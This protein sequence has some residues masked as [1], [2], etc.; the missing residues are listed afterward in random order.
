MQQKV[1]TVEN[2]TTSRRTLSSTAGEHQFLW[3]GI[4]SELPLLLDHA[5]LS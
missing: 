4:E 1:R 2:L 5:E 3:D